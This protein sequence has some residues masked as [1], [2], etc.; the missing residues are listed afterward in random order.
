MPSYEA[1]KGDPLDMPRDA[2]LVSLILQAADV[3]DYEPRLIPQLLEF[4]HRYVQDVLQDSQ[5]FADHA[6]HKELE[7]DDVRLAIESRV[8]HSFTGPPSRETMMELAEK[9]N[10]IPL[11][12]IPEKFGLRLPPER[13]TLTKANFQ[14]IPKVHTSKRAMV[15]QL[16][17]SISPL[18]RAQLQSGATPHQGTVAGEGS[19]ISGDASMASEMV[20][21][22]MPVPS[23]HP[24]AAPSL[25]MPT[26]AAQ[27][28]Q[29]QEDDDYDMEGIPAFVVAR[30]WLCYS[31]LP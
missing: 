31:S 1:F 16:N 26:S 3:D 25:T 5:V 6:G 30:R 18:A 27:K 12:L 22:A 24:V 15:G 9:K 19:V 23:A 28:V 7:V 13:N 14:I 2:K 10:S 21:L 4:A 20:Q 17:Q 29:A 8:A 11:P